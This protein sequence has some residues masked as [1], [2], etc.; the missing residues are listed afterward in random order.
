MGTEL[1]ELVITMACSVWFKRNK[2]QLGEARQ[3]AHEFL[4]RA[5]P[6]L[7]EY[8]LAHLWPTQFKEATDGRWVPPTF[9]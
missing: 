9:P 8:Q 1:I 6:L 3:L 2:T 7:Q 4:M 5:R